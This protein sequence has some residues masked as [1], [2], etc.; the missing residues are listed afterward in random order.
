MTDQVTRL[1]LMQR[2]RNRIIEVLELTSS[3]DHQL[4]Y[5]EAVQ[6]AYVPDEVI[7]KWGD[8]VNAHTLVDI[9]FPVFSAG[10][11]AAI[12]LFN[13][14]ANEIMKD[15]PKAMPD[16]VTLQRSE[17]WL[18]LRQAALECLDVMNR[19]GRFPEDDQLNVWP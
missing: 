14:A 2:L 5:Q 10:E 3:F 7:E 19:R 18:Q 4:A 16:L 1:V 9:T 15:L 13:D 17:P 6:I 11:V 12:N 8:W